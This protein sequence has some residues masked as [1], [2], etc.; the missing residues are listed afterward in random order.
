[1]SPLLLLRTMKVPGA[2][3]NIKLTPPQA[4][5]ARNAFG[6]QVYCLLFDW[7]VARINDSIRGAATEAMAFIG[8]LDVFGFEIFEV[9]SFEQ[10]CIN[11][12]NEKLHQFFLKFVFK[13]EE[14]IYK[15]E[16]IAGIK[17]EVRRQ[18]A[19]HR[20]DRAAAD[21]H[22]QAARLDV[23]DAQGDR[24][25]VLHVHLRRAR[26]AGQGASWRAEAA[27]REDV[28]FVVKHF[29]GDV[30]YACANFLEKNNDSL[31]QTL[32]RSCC[33][34]R[35][36]VARACSRRRR[37]A[38]R[39]RPPRSQAGRALGPPS[40]RVEALLSTTSTR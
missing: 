21:G 5:A 13:M 36:V 11:F 7:I 30:R 40:L 37:R 12:A 27:P 33:S 26:Q 3:Y 10:L 15:E 39:R 28:E 25:Q 8:L 20:P 35:R 16:A 6:K 1:M 4:V 38:R 22:L 31:D 18:P 23:Q 14:Q 24:R 17:I 34:S 29:A 19:V 9:N 32:Q 2:V